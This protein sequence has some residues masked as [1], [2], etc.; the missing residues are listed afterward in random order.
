V[1]DHLS[2][3]SRPVAD[4]NLAGIFRTL[5]ALIGG[6]EM[7]LARRLG[8]DVS[9]I[10]DLEAGLIEQIPPWPVT[11]QIVE[12]Y[13]MLAGVDVST[14]LAALARLAPPAPP[15]RQLTLTP[16]D[17]ARTSFVEPSSVGIA[18]A[19]APSH[20]PS[21][22]QRRPEFVEVPRPSVLPAALPAR[23][24]PGP[25]P[26]AISGRRLLVPAALAVAAIVVGYGLVWL[27]PR[28]LYAIAGT[29]PGPL[30][31]PFRAAA[32]TALVWTAPTRDGLLQID[33]ADPRVRK[34]DRLDTRTANRRRSAQP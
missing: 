6:T 20:R 32:H 16:L 15:G 26:P 30:D 14:V 5:R 3:F 22:P 4:P 23:P 9:V 24:G 34:S 17:A 12:R 13:G 19:T 28:P 33:I 18:T 1:R 21:Q 7:D 29:L 10:M 27:A 25:K 8:T 2:E 11:V 31:R